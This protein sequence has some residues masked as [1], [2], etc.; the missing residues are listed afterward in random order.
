[1]FF[2]LL[3]TNFIHL[4]QFLCYELDNKSKQS[5]YETNATDKRI[6]NNKKYKYS[7]IFLEDVF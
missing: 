3:Q 7:H 1:M 5:G 2:Y 4:I 6:W